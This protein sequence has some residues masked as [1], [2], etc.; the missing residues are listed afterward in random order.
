[1]E[2][3]RLARLM[4]MA[5]ATIWRIETRGGSKR[6]SS[7]SESVDEAVE[8]L[9]KRYEELSPDT[10]VLKYRSTKTNEKGQDSEVFTIPKSQSNNQSTTP[11]MNDQNLMLHLMQLSQSLGKLEAE[12][13]YIRRDIDDLK[14]Q[15]KEV[16]TMLTDDDT[17]NDKTAI[18][19]LGDLVKQVPD[20]ANGI[21]SFRELS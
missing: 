4:R 7:E 16:Y 12:Q 19:K 6:G 2:F 5:N 13:N 10:Y 18:E 1:M 9:Q 17:S 8:T 21:K 14:S 15:L 3:E 20:I 11:T